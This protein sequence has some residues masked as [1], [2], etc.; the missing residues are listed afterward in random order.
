MRPAA[1][2]A[3]ASLASSSQSARRAQP[4]AAPGRAPAAVAAARLT[5]GRAEP[6]A[7][8]RGTAPPQAPIGRQRPIKGEADAAGRVE[9]GPAGRGWPVGGPRGVVCGWDR[10]GASMGRGF[11]CAGP[12]SPCANLGAGVGTGRAEA[13][14]AGWWSS[15]ALAGDTETS[16][17]SAFPRSCQSGTRWLEFTGRET[18]VTTGDLRCPG[19]RAYCSPMVQFLP[20]LTVPSVLQKV[21]PVFSCLPFSL[22]PLGF[23]FV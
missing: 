7:R 11:G 13:L 23:G 12:Q 16:L 21:D 22:T 6:P 20:K 10:G 8:R 3:P 19:A 17:F 18:E 15:A 2:P 4:Q 9:A 5:P 14:A 1:D